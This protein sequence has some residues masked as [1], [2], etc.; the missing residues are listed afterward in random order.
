VP[1]ANQLSP[2]ISRFNG[3][4][5]DT[6]NFGYPYSLRVYPAV[7]PYIDELL[8]CPA[9]PIIEHLP[10]FKQSHLP[11]S[12]GL[13]K[14]A[15]LDPVT[16]SPIAR[17]EVGEEVINV[18][19]NSVEEARQVTNSEQLVDPHRGVDLDEVVDSDQVMKL[20]QVKDFDQTTDSAQVKDLQISKPNVQDKVSMSK[21]ELGYPLNLSVYP[22]V[23]PHLEE[24]LYAPR[25]FNQEIKA[26]RTENLRISPLVSLKPD[27]VEELV[28]SHVLKPDLVEELIDSQKAAVSVFFCYQ[29]L[30]LSHYLRF[31][32]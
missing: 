2:L 7:Y 18:S 26:P 8:Y 12:T 4:A 1:P 6:A 10:L 29:N 27:L 28:D 30:L 31:F 24:M 22:S 32:L 25:L 3:E 11:Q 21:V 23:Y 15:E 14:A 16:T 20:D 19:D 17:Q 9:P 13:C 5:V